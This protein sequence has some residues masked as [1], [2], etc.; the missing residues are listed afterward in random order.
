MQGLLLIDKPK[1]ITSFGAVAKVKWLCGTKRVGHTGTLDPMATGVLP[2]LVGRATLL[3]KY[4]LEADKEYVAEVKLGLTTDTLDITGNVL[5]TAEVDISLSQL[6]TVARSFVGKIKQTPPMYSAIKKDGT[7]LYKLARQGVEVERPSREVTINSL[8]ISGFNGNEF[9]MR[10]NC[11]K[12]TYIRS[13]A[14]DLGKALGTGATLTSLRRVDTAGYKIVRC[15]NLESLTKEN[16]AE[17]LINEEKAVEH[18]PLVSVSEKQA[19]RFSNGG[20]LALERLRDLKEPAPNK[21]Y[22]VRY[23]DLFLGLGRVDDTSTQ[24]KI[25]CLIN[26]VNNN[27]NKE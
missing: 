6:E 7:P 4:L 10:V 19:V 27:D 18:Y 17:F 22:R 13:L 24:L 20:A 15:V 2:I 14:D 12:G 21:I 25:E 16:V 5:S 3:S 26:F 8:E 11:S 23:K 9:S 1:D